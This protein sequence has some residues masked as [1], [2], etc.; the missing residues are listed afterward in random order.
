M[1]PG[2]PYAIAAQLAYPG[3]QVVACVGDGGFTMMMPELLTA[4]KY[5]LPITVVVFKN[6]SLA[7]VIYE[8]LDEGFGEFGLE[9]QPL[10]FVKFAE[11]CGAA[12]FRCRHPGEV[13]PAIEAALR[14]G[15][16][17]VVEAIVESH[18]RPAAPDQYKA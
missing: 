11:A 13:A 1:G 2:L 8:Q 9:L 7:H 10:D 6:N 4:V 12:G 17:A 16:P 5:R 18:E 15:K 14:A 3:R